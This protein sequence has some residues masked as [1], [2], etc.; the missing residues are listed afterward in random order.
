MVYE[1]TSKTI[2]GSYALRPSDESDEIMLGVI[3]RAQFMYP[4][5]KIYALN[6]LSSHTTDL[7]GSDKPKELAKFIGYV[8]SNITREFNR[9]YGL[10]YG[11]FAPKRAHV[12]PISPNRES[13]EWRLAYA[14]SQGTKEDLVETPRH[15]DGVTGVA[16]LEKG[17]PLE[18]VW[19][20]RTAEGKA[21]RRN[22]TF[23]KYAYATRYQV[24]LSPL[25]CWD[26]S[27]EK[28]RKRVTTIVDD[29]AAKA[30]ER[31]GDNVLGM[32]KVRAFAPTFT[33]EFV[34]RSPAPMV[35]AAGKKAYDALKGV[36]VDFCNAFRR[37][38][39]SSRTPGAKAIEFPP[40]SFPPGLPMTPGDAEGFDLNAALQLA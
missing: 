23:D 32:E 15:W 9:L 1:V 27:D 5:V 13:L 19:F 30:I 10:R 21:R 25:P 16:A 14:L 26:D 39:T 20:D 28:W 35:L 33:P 8:K 6:P 17:D 40:F 3:G 24:K 34:K 31:R 11:V 36:L 37:A 12:I 38:S 29:I 7:L 4:S 22:E 2:A 18:G